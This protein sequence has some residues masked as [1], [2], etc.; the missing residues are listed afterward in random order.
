[1]HTHN[2][3][4]RT[5]LG[6]RAGIVS[7]LVNT[8]LFVFKYWAGIVSGSVALIADAWH[9]LSDSLTSVIVIVGVKL[10][11][12][13]ADGKHPYGYGRWE[14]I[15]AIFIAVIL[16]IVAYEFGR[17]SIERLKAGE[18]ANFGLIAI[19]VTAASI[20]V[21]EGLA[22]YTLYLARKTG[23]TSIK[24]DAWHHRSDALSS[25]IVLA[26]IF[27]RDYFWWIDGV[28]GLI[29]SALLFYAVFSIMR[30]SINKLLGVEP[31]QEMIEKVKAVTCSCAGFD[32]EA[33]HFHLHNYGDHNELTFHIVLEETMNI[34]EAHDLADRIEGKI[35]EK[36]EIEATIHID[37]RESANKNSK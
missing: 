21:K 23:N 22:Q 8:V 26:G 35:R 13:K 27:L 10:S 4:Q 11:S 25:V 1:M 14:Q 36:L 2:Q 32:V 18:T 34:K 16:A 19:I 29:I 3:A 5:K 6:Y 12:K 9:T 17:E 20:L 30:E 24:A 15:A 28:L 7:L 33:H 37:P 31:D